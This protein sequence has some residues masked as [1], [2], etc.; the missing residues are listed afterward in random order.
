MSNNIKVGLAR[1]KK[2]ESGEDGKG[3]AYSAD[4]N[5]AFPTFIHQVPS[6]LS[7]LAIVRVPAVSAISG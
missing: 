6:T 7:T 1:S 4:W 5:V 2:T 3:E